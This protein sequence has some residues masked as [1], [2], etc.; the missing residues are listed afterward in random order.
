VRSTV[1]CVSGAQNPISL[2]PVVL[3]Q[4]LVLAKDLE[5]CIH[6]M[7]EVAQVTLGTFWCR[8]CGAIARGSLTLGA[9]WS[10]SAIAIETRNVRHT[11]DAKRAP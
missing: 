3:S 5:E 11:G 4:L 6:P 10:R 8:R 1:A 9:P 7:A 2:I